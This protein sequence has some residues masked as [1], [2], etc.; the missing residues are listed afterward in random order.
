L[1]KQ[2]ENGE[3]TTKQHAA[4]EKMI[5]MDADE[6]KTKVLHAVTDN[7]FNNI[8]TYLKDV[9]DEHKPEVKA[10]LEQKIANKAKDKSVKA[11]NDAERLQGLVD[12]YL[13]D[14]ESVPGPGS[15]P[16]PKGGMGKG[17]GKLKL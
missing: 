13:G 3:I 15:Q 2:L 5:Q 6:N 7:D 8:E 12:K 10:A 17:F 14:V 4:R 9:A 1:D 11:A 16:K